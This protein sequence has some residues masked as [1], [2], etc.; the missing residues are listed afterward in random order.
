MR[1]SRNRPTG[2]VKSGCGIRRT[3]NA[4]AHRL[5]LQTGSGAIIESEAAAWRTEAAED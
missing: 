5:Q 2:S 3:T 4:V 1:R